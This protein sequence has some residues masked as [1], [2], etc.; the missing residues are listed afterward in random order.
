MSKQKNT[1]K[2]ALNLLIITLI[3]SLIFCIY[4]CSGSKINNCHYYRIGLVDSS[5]FSGYYFISV[6]DD[7]NKEIYILSKRNASLNLSDRIY[8][9]LA[10]GKYFRL[11]LMKLD[12]SLEIHSRYQQDA[13]I[14]LDSILLY[15]EGRMR[16]EI[17]ESSNIVDKYYIKSSDISK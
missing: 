17:Y 10:G 15:S 12:T 3:I 4:S 13:G 7:F 2:K 5:W 11:C 1:N 9:I 14:I 8:D 16:V 6:Y